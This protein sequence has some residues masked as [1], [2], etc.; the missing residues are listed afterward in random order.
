VK[1]HHGYITGLF[2][3]GRTFEDKTIMRIEPVP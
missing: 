2:G 1:A 3:S